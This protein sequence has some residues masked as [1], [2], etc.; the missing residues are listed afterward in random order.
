MELL[1]H[2]VEVIN[3]KGKCAK[4][5]RFCGKEFQIIMLHC[6]VITE[7]S[8]WSN[9]CQNKIREQIDLM[10]LESPAFGSKMRRYALNGEAEKGY[11]IGQSLPTSMY[12]GWMHE[13]TQI[14]RRTLLR[15]I[16]HEDAF[17]PEEK[18]VDRISSVRCVCLVPDGKPRARLRRHSPSSWLSRCLCRRKHRGFPRRRH[19]SD[20][21]QRHVPK[22]TSAETRR[23]FESWRETPPG[24]LAVSHFRGNTA[25]RSRVSSDT[26]CRRIS[27]GEIRSRHNAKVSVTFYGARSSTVFARLHKPTP[28]L[29]N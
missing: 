14:Y 12:P 8:S 9:V 22:G 23:T 18:R 1:N 11:L 3:I 13:R 17:G 27:L 26:S 25:R 28:M 20:K 19:Y 4:I 10:I 15:A 21:Y 5:A 16:I 6:F 24:N 2:F 29:N 7:R